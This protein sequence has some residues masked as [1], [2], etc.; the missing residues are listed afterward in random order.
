ME[1]L[2]SV[3]IFAIVM[4]VSVGT[5]IVLLTAGSVAQ[6]S[7]SITM[8]ISFALDSMARNIR[9]GYDY[10]CTDTVTGNGFELPDDTLDCAEG[11]SVLIF[12][13]G[14]TGY[15]TAYRYD[16]GEQALFQK[17]DRPAESYYGS[18]IRLTSEDIAIE[19]FAFT[20]VGSE[21]GDAVQPTV[22]M[23]LKALPIEARSQVHPFFIQTTVTSK[24]LNI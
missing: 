23:T 10:H 7:Q 9:T 24:Y 15:R 11:A 2:V 19:P 1:M 5:L 18:W 4:T 12:T 8:N 21:G 20:L 22:R 17:V 16:E 14:R 3:S 6:S 13:E